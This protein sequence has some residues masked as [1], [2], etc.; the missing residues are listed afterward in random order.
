MML[1]LLLETRWISEKS[2]D[3]VDKVLEARFVFKEREV[4]EEERLRQ[5]LCGNAAERDEE[6][7]NE[8]EEKEEVVRR[9]GDRSRGEEMT[10]D[11]TSFRL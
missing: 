11:M 8:E 6:E 3:L 7:D 2:E 9:R 4:D 5:L 10:D 1:F